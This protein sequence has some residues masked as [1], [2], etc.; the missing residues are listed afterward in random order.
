MVIAVIPVGFDI[1]HER[2]IPEL[3]LVNGHSI[4][5]DSVDDLLD[6]GVDHVF[7]YVATDWLHEKTA[8][9]LES[10][11]AMSAYEITH[12]PNVT[13]RLIDKP[14]SIFSQLPDD[15]V[16][17]VWPTEIWHAGQEIESATTCLDQLDLTHDGNNRSRL[18]FAVEFMRWFG[19]VLIWT[20]SD[21]PWEEAL[22]G[23]A[24]ARDQSG[25]V[26]SILE[27]ETAGPLPDTVAAARY[28]IAIPK[29]E[30]ARVRGEAVNPQVTNH[31]ALKKHVIRTSTTTMAVADTAGCVDLR[32]LNRPVF[33]EDL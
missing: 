24:V 2:E 19:G 5:Q 22:H 33:V 16:I 21:A 6:C 17:L 7:I 13:V 28:L 29:A 26:S 12:A 20:Q 9:I 18:H 32:Y 31:A 11:Q 30:L 4:L 14:L 27:P 3:F 25:V 10:D 1:T 23:C 15:D 8:A